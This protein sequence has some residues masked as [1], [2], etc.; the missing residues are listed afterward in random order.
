M[1]LGPANFTFFPAKISVF[2]TW[3]QLFGTWPRCQVFLVFLGPG[4]SFL[5]PGPDP[6][7]GIEH[8]FLDFSTWFRGHYRTLEMLYRTLYFKKIAPAAR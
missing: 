1:F 5:G 2:G 8:D 4:N 6:K 7:T 3:K